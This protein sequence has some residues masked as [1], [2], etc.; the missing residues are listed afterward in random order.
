LPIPTPGWGP[1]FFKSPVN[2]D[3]V[4]I[5][6]TR[7]GRAGQ[8]LIIIVS[9]KGKHLRVSAGVVPMVEIEMNPVRGFLFVANATTH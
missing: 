4:T 8:V 1:I 6:L 3:G 7:P 9:T 2:P 5:I